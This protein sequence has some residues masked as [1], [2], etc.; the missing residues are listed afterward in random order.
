MTAAVA[1]GRLIST[2]RRDRRRPGALARRRSVLLELLGAVVWCYG[3]FSLFIDGARHVEVRLVMLLLGLFGEDRV[4]GSLGDTFLIFGPGGRPMLAELTPSCSA[5][6]SLLALAALGFF[7][8][9]HRPHALLGFVAAAAWVVLANQARLIASLLAG[10]WYGDRAL[11][12]FHDWVGALFNF[13]YTL[14]GLLILITISM[15]SAERAEQ[16]RNGRH[17]ANRPDNLAKPGLGYRVADIEPPRPGRYRVIS[18]IHR[19]LIPR[20]LSHWMGDRRER[21][22]VDYRLGHLSPQDRANQVAALT[23]KGLGVHTA[24]LLAVAAHETDPIV[25][26]ALAGAVAARQWEPVTRPQIASLRLW[27]RAWL[28]RAPATTVGSGDR[29][30]AVTGAGGPAGVAVIRALRAAGHQ[31]LALDA[32]ADA[33]GFRLANTG[34]V[35]PRADEPGYG[36]ALLRIVTEHQ[37]DA[38]ICTVAEE[39]AALGPLTY[40]LHGLGCQTW[41]PEQAAADSCLDKR[42][43][44]DVMYQAGIP[45]PGVAT[46]PAAASQLPGPWIVKPRNGRGSRHVVTADTLG[47]L[48]AAMATVP[49]PI[50]QTRISGREFTADA[51]VGRD[52][53]L[54]TCVPR[55]RDETKAGISVRGTTF[56]SAAVTAVVAAT[57]RAVGMT[58]PANVQGFVR[59]SD[60]LVGNPDAAVEVVI[61]EVNPR[62]SGGLPLTLAAGADVVGTYLAGIMDAEAPLPRLPFTPGVRMARHF[63]EVYSGPDGA[64]LADPLAG[65]VVAT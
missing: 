4:S 54:L 65:A 63:T 10:V 18:F 29:T 41:L 36:Q 64:E 35:L 1:E 59:D 47:T 9:R 58:G 7:L 38:L 8:L 27:A 13:A 43:F 28:M 39:Y 14:I 3:G 33:V 31:V 11:V 56:D 34:A 42:A 12:L 60:P 62:F 22:R 50:A 30:V 26:D 57:L 40:S 6:A 49:D 17:T 44:A 61:I 24:T 55:W 53:T 32:N 52:G 25:L 19:F 2:V 16:D 23:A 48:S 20:P 5:L 45:H 15:H 37:P 21:N 51:L 46:T